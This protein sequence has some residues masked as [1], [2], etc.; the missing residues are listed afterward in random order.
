[1][2]KFYTLL[3][4]VLSALFFSCKTASKSYDKGDYVKA[5]DLAIKKL[6]KD[7]SD[8]E[9]KALLMA[10]Y[11]NAT[12]IS[13]SHI[14]SLSA[15]TNISY[16]SIYYEYAKLQSLYQKIEP[17]PSL[18]TLV[19]ATDYT[20][21]MK[22]YGEKA[23]E[24]HFE[25]GMEQMNKESKP[26][27]RNAYREFKSALRFADT[28]SIREKMDEAYNAAILNVVILPV[29]N[30]FNPYQS[31]TSYQLQNF[32]DE[33]MREMRYG[34][35]T[36]F[37]KIYS[38]WDAR[39]KNIVPDQVVELRMGRFEIGRPYD[40]NQTRTVS[41]DVVVK[42]IVYKPDS[43]I[44]QYGKVSAQVITTQRTLASQGEIYLTV[45]DNRGHI[46][47]T[48]R[49]KGEHQWKTQFAIYRGDD[50]ALNDNDR[51]LVN[52][53]TDNYPNEDEITTELLNRIRNDLQYK[54]KSFFSRY[55]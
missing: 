35:N 2:T 4:V 14:R 37:L 6:Q 33:L 17:F 12:A 46:I 54:L 26:A 47:W 25:K 55:D 10:A 44:K 1:M 9:T 40:R 51:A 42:E 15:G 22:T 27:Y 34:T 48:D 3:L 20:G 49:V 30:Q 21:F 39:S 29:S 31:N 43:I 5:I 28:R 41:K 38:D 18:A 50:R 13:E 19:H 8:G 11:K 32:Q 52:Q 24:D 16:E 45:S 36:E 7:P 23:A 53:S